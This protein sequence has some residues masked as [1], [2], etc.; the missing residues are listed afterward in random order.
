MQPA[1]HGSSQQNPSPLVEEEPKGLIEDRIE[2]VPVRTIYALVASTIKEHRQG[3]KALTR[4][5]ELRPSLRGKSVLAWQHSRS[6]HS[7]QR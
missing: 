4:Q 6:S 3:I 7:T 1:L 5:T 2:A